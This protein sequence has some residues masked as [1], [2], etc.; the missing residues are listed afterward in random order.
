MK[1]IKQSVKILAIFGITSAVAVTA[2]FGQAQPLITV[3]EL[4]NGNFNG[5]PLPSFQ[6]PDPFS[7]IVT[8]TY[9]LPFPGVPGDVQLFEPNAAGTNQ[10]SDIIRFDGNGNLF[11]FSELEPTDVPP[12]DPADVNQFPPPV[13]GLQTVALLE[14][15]PEGNNGAMYNPAGG[16]P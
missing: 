10:L 2:A 13:P 16:G 7:G 14:N 3:D 1:S 8:L 5:Q 15:G 12:F 6:S 4:G 9:R 11:F